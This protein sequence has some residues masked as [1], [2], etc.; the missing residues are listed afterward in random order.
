MVAASNQLTSSLSR[1]WHVAT[2]CIAQAKKAWRRAEHKLDK[3]EERFFA[4]TVALVEAQVSALE[5]IAAQAEA[6]ELKAML[7]EG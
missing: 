4:A 3:A 5:A 7:D 1:P 6:E 2:G